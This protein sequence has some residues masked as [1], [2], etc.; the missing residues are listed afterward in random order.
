MEAADCFKMLVPVY[1]TTWHYILEGHDL[2]IHCHENP[3]SH[4]IWETPHTG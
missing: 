4:R 2:N 3:K 1:Q